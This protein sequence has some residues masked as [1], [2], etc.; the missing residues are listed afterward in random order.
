M[1]PAKILVTT[2]VDEFEIVAVTDQREI[3]LKVLEE[4]FVLRPLVA[5]GELVAFGVRRLDAT[6]SCALHNGAATAPLAV[7]QL[8]QST[9]N[10]DH[11]AY[12]FNG[13]RRG[14]HRNIELIA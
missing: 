8:K 12:V 4:N 2:I 6:F 11:S 13:S 7:S 1:P 5:P 14:L 3:H 10:L 9:L